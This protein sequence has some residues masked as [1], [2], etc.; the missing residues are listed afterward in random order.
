MKGIEVADGRGD[1]FD[2]LV[3]VVEK[4]AGVLHA[5]FAQVLHR[6]DA[7]AGA[8][9]LAEM[10]DRI[11]GRAGAVRQLDRLGEVL[12]HPLRRAADAPVGFRILPGASV[13]N[14]GERGH[15]IDQATSQL[16]QGR[17]REALVD[18]FHRGI[19][20]TAYGGQRRTG[21]H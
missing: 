12:A 9:A 3:S 20:V 5:Q 19:E 17:V 14:A 10:R 4:L 15:R 21:N 6:R 1:G 18:P 7:I 13:G 8:E 16:E 11:T 2:W